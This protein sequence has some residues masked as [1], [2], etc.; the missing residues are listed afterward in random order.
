MANQSTE[1]FIEKALKVWGDAY[2]Y[3]QVVYRGGLEPVTII[4][5]VHGPFQQ[6]PYNHL[7]G[8]QCQ[9]CSA[10]AR[11]LTTGEFI[12]RARAIFP[13]YDYSLVEYHLAAIKV[14][15][16]CPVHGA[17][18][19]RPAELLSYKRGCPVCCAKPRPKRGPQFRWAKWQIELMREAL[20]EYPA[21]A[22]ERN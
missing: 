13:D 18:E 14:T 1:E 11:K 16:I 2:D 22:M 7:H 4:C 21:R 20:R 19:R 17:F 15:I 8:H 10:E 9:Q 12:D 5:R 6:F 3:S